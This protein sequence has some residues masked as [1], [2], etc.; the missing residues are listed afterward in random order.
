MAKSALDIAQYFINEAIDN[1]RPL[2]QLR[3]QKLVYIFHGFYMAFE[4][5][6]DKPYFSEKVYAWKYG[7]VIPSIYDEYVL[8]GSRMI[9]KYETKFNSHFNKQTVKI[10]NA[11]CSIT[12]DLDTVNLVYWLMQEGTP[13]HCSYEETDRDICIDNQ[14]TKVYFKRY[15]KTNLK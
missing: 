14:L 4:I 3:L 2:T 10:L 12:K 15:I 8:Y 5:D 7:P 11:V 9:G 1:K 6:G 13:W